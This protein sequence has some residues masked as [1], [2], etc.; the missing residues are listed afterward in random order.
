[1]K[2]NNQ[3]SNTIINYILSGE[4]KVGNRLPSER[5]LAE[6]LG[7]S[8]SKVREVIQKLCSL[9]YLK[10]VRGSGTYLVKSNDMIASAASATKLEWELDFEKTKLMEIWQVRYILESAAAG[11]AANRATKE[12]LNNIREAFLHYEELVKQ[13]AP[14]Q[15]I[16]A[17]TMDFHNSIIRATHNQVLQDIVE[18]MSDFMKF[19]RDK[20]QTISDSDTRAVEHHRKLMDMIFEGDPEHARACMQDH[21]LDVRRDIYAYIKHEEEK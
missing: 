2:E 3:L 17:A 13:S 9:G 12:D 5:E 10:S 1:M 19:T 18:S 15:E 20:T 7:V 16:V 11:I 14:S 21:L 6:K 8:R 4:F